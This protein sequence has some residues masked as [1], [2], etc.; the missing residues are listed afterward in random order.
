VWV[1]II[2]AFAINDPPSSAY[3]PV[4]RTLEF[5]TE[6]RCLAAKDWVSEQL[7]NEVASMNKILADKAKVGEVREFVAVRFSADCKLK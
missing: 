2:V 7:G 3:A 1:L 5:T 4:I 6:E